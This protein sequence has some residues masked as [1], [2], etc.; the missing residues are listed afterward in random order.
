MVG[1]FRLHS[2]EQSDQIAS[3]LACTP[4]TDPNNIITKSESWTRRSQHSGKIEVL[5]MSSS[6]GKDANGK[7]RKRA[8]TTDLEDKKKIAK[9]IFEQEK[10][11]ILNSIPENYRN[12]FGQIGFTKWG[13]CLL[14]ILILNP[15]DVPPGEVRGKW[16]TMYE[17]VRLCFAGNLVFF[18]GARINHSPYSFPFCTQR[19]HRR[20]ASTL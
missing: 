18:G 2:S 10:E 6:A 16:L 3:N 11:E 13:K 15:Y 9:R 5:K 14:P 17:K 4:S 7:K 19:I 20:E 8:D 1:S 12:K